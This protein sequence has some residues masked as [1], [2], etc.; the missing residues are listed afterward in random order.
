[1]KIMEVIAH[2][3]ADVLVLNEAAFLKPFLTKPKFEK[4]M[5]KLGYVDFVYEN[6]TDWPFHMRALSAF[7][8]NILCSK[9]PLRDPASRRMKGFHGRPWEHRSVV[10][11]TI[12]LP[13][14]DSLR[15]FGTHLE[16]WDTSGETA[17]RQCTEVIGMTKANG[18][19]S[20]NANANATHSLICGDLNSFRRAEKPPERLKRFPEPHGFAITEALEQAGWMDSFVACGVPPPYMTVWSTARVDFIYVSPSL[21]PQLKQSCHFKNS[22]SDHTPVILDLA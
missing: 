1:M 16:I 20:K 13:S 17:L 10:A 22:V 7:F 8:G 21:K 6:T 18:E 5:R 14:G 12:E 9:Q 19:D 3:D 2:L 4:N 11:G 15:V